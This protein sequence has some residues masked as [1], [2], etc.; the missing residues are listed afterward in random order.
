MGERHLIRGAYYRHFKGK[1]Y[2]VLHLAE[3]TETGEDM[4]VYQAMYGEEKIYARPYDMFMSEVDKEK[5]P[6]AIQTYRFEN[7]YD[8]RKH[9]DG[10]SIEKMF[11]KECRP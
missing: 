9:F 7:K 4:V 5:Y 3:H 11:K 8:L 1:W 6:K 10:N 2:K